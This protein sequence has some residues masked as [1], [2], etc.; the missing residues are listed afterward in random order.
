MAGTMSN[1]VYILQ[2]T[3]FP[4]KYSHIPEWQLQEAE[5]ELKLNKR[6]YYENAIR[7][8]YGF[9]YPDNIAKLIIEYWAKKRDFA[10]YKTKAAKR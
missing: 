4:N 9:L 10:K 7:T 8:D 6:H 5:Y 2:W 3:P 1:Y